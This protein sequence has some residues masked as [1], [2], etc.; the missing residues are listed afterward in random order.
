MSAES[1][2]YRLAKALYRR[3][4]QVTLGWLGKVTIFAHRLFPRFTERMTYRYIAREPNSPF[5]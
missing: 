1:V 3:R 2:A 5:K 4:S